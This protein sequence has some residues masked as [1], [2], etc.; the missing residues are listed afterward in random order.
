MAAPALTL[1][2]KLMAEE[3]SDTVGLLP[4]NSFDEMIT[5]TERGKMW[6]FPVDNEFGKWVT[7][8]ERGNWVTCAERGNWVT[9]A[10]RGKLVT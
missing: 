2:D 4:V 1:F 5:W 6:R 3:L 7:C 9:C 8:A 10:E